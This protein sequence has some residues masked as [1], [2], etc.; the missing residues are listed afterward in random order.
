MSSS[1]ARSSA[2]LLMLAYVA[3]ISLGLP[4]ALL[5]VAW[6]SLRASFDLPQSML[7]VPLAA[8]ATAYFTSPA[9][10]REG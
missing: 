10:W 7:G 8:A 6:P 1:P 2:P 4:D 3:F 5:G 9:C